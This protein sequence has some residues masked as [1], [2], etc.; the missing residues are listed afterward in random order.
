MDKQYVCIECGEESDIQGPCPM[1]GLPMIPAHD[2][3]TDDD[4]SFDDLNDSAT[5][6]D[7]EEEEEGEASYNPYEE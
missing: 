2:E 3:D 4:T 5:A 7:E 6:D 1:C